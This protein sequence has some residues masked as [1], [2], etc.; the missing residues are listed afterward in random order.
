MVSSCSVACKSRSPLL[1]ILA[2]LICFSVTITSIL[3]VT[4]VANSARNQQDQTWKFITR[5]V[6]T[7]VEANLGII[8]ACLVVLNQVVRRFFSSVFG[9]STAESG[10][11]YADGYGSG[12]GAGSTGQHN[13]SLRNRQH[14]TFDDTV[15][16]ED[17]NPGTSIQGGA[18]LR[19]GPRTDNRS[20]RMKPVTFR[21]ASKERRKSDE[22]YIMSSR[23]RKTAVKAVSRV[24]NL[25][26]SGH[27]TRV[28]ASRRRWI[29]RLH[30][31]LPRQRCNRQD[32]HTIEYQRPRQISIN[33]AH[34]RQGY[35]TTGRQPLLR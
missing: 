2:V 12:M 6:W 16:D 13:P 10:R 27:R 4:A 3:R 31:V 33:H 19:A 18:Q 5:G 21:G 9:S 7:L 20:Y 1:G 29:S 22:K 8:C 34:H 17:I 28:W 24:W 32:T 23:R 25:S 15:D 26:Q 14:L 11:A 35:A 30:P